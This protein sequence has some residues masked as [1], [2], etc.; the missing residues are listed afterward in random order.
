MGH[1]LLSLDALTTG[2]SKEMDPASGPDRAPGN[3]GA[4][5]PDEREPLILMLA[6]TNACNLS[7]RHCYRHEATAFG[8]E[9]KPAEI[10]DVLEQFAELCQIEGY[11]GGIVFS[12]GEPLLHPH[13]GLAIRLARGLGLHCRVNTSATLAT[14]GVAEALRRWGLE[15]AQVSLDG[16][17][18]VTHEAIRGP[19]TWDL[20]RRGIAALQAAG[21][22]VEL[23][24]TLIRGR[25]DADPAAFMRL[26]RNWG[27]SAV[28][29]SRLIPIGSGAGFPAYDG[30]SWLAVL[31]GLGSERIAGVVGDIRDSTFDR[32]FLLG[33]PHRP[34]PEEAVRVLAVDADGT[35]L[36]SRRLPIPVGNVR[37][38]PLARMW[39]H[40]LLER[41]RR[42]MPTGKCQRCD[43]VELCRGGSRAAARA[44]SGDLTLAPDPACWVELP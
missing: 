42:E 15:V 6:L 43:L 37:S 36:A 26:A 27:V 35:C 11:R 3:P 25:N 44:G 40:P 28:S 41:L 10:F 24:V 34:G 21:I 20:M 33:A 17:D 14:A 18:R 38:E 32:S 9:L 1:R 29:Y 39:H 7:C 19:G 16:P 12:G 22:A 8:D 31:E 30:A 2:C 5:T 4:S 23:K 13:L